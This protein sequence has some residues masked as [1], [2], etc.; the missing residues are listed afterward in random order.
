MA[1]KYTL[2]LCCVFLILIFVSHTMAHRVS[3]YAIKKGNVIEGEGS[4]G[5]GRPCKDCDIV[6]LDSNGQELN[7]AKTDDMGLFK[8]TLSPE[9]AKFATK[10]IMDGGPGHRA[11]W[12]LEGADEVYLH[13]K[14]EGS[15][16]AD[17]YQKQQVGVGIEDI[18]ILRTIIR[19]EVQ[20]AIEP[21]RRELLHYK[22]E[23]PGF[24][25][26]FG[27]IGYIVGIAGLWL[28]FRACKRRD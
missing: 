9:K 10:V 11:E 20:R 13:A 22:S 15:T 4:F 16:K 26:I 3:V 21:I 2:T 7:R 8:V 5:K 12:V 28:Y 17:S 23:G 24:K 18:E 19:E 27:G 14:D 25:E 6:V 1:Y